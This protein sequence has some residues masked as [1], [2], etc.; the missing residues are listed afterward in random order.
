MILEWVIGLVGLG[1]F[2]VAIIRVASDFKER[3]NKAEGLS[4]YTPEQL[5]RKLEGKSHIK[6]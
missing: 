4:H 1:V 6:H 2:V 3:E 5:I